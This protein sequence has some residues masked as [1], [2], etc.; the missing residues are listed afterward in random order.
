MKLILD[1]HNF[2]IT[3]KTS[4][5][6]SLKMRF[7]SRYHLELTHPPFTPNKLLLRFLQNHSFWIQKNYPNIP[8]KK[9][10]SRLKSLKILGQSYQVI[11]TLSS[12][13]S[14]VFFHQQQLLRLNT[15]SLSTSYL[16]KLFDKKFRPLALKLIKKEV[17]SLSQKHDFVYQRIS[18]KNQKSRYGSC[19]TSGNLNF[20][21]QIILFPPK[22]FQHVI[23]H[24]LTHLSIK[25]HSNK[26][27][28][29]L[30]LYDPDWRSHRLWL[31]TNAPKVMLFS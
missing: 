23:L 9:K 15:T 14:L 24:E 7:L 13:D 25:N 12:I 19:S 11:I 30:A 16:K 3:Q 6:S 31:K 1:S 5:S 22:I 21:W 8:L 4:L 29:Q 28:Q 2:K 18:V 27:W 20:N 10:L 26:F 17:D